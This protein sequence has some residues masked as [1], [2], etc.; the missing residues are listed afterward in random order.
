MLDDWGLHPPSAEARRDLLEVV[1]ARHVRRSTIIASQLPVEEWHQAVGE[2]T[3]ADAILDRLVN[4]RAPLRAQGRVDAAQPET[5][6][7]R[8]GPDG[9]RSRMMALRG[10]CAFGVG[11]NVERCGITPGRAGPGLDMGPARP[12]DRRTRPLT[13]REASR[14]LRRREPKLNGGKRGTHRRPLRKGTGTATA[15][16]KCRRN[17]VQVLSESRSNASELALSGH[18]NVPQVCLLPVRS[19]PRIG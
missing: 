5:A 10:G 19:P 9:G 2:G 1:D 4:Y 3:I 16:F 18:P 11:N 7:A 14:T 15:A 13:R 17:R 12:A 8:R 6:A